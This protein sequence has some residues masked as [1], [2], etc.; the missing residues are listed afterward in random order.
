MMPR[1]PRWLGAA[2][3]ALTLLGLTFGACSGAPP[4]ASELLDSGAA[5]A[6]T[7]EPESSVTTNSRSS[8]PS[9]GSLESEELVGLGELGL[10]P[11]LI[12]SLSP[13]TGCDLDD[14]FSSC[15]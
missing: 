2:L 6:T 10:L 3:M 9:S 7:T 14:P 12:Q 13:S 8:R 1:T 4:E 11:S 15:Q 5:A